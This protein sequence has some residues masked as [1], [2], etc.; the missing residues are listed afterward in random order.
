MW[1]SFQLSIR[2][3]QIQHPPITTTKSTSRANEGI[4]RLLKNEQILYVY[5]F[6]LRFPRRNVKLNLRAFYLW[7][8]MR[9][10][11]QLVRHPIPASSMACSHSAPMLYSD[12]ERESNDS[13]HPHSP[14]KSHNLTR[15]HLN[16]S[17]W[18]YKQNNRYNISF[19]NAD[20]NKF[21]AE[22]CRL[23]KF[24]RNKT[25]FVKF[26]IIVAGTARPLRSTKKISFLLVILLMTNKPATNRTL[27]YQQKTF[28]TYCVTQNS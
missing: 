15:A 9:L 25:A 17:T 10:E 23:G 11:I 26:S 7:Q 18:Q 12:D 27:Q 2:R 1:L 16:A 8:K 21:Y 24:P 22:G 3:N 20:D 5:C 4:W 19:Q 28:T 6:F 13:S 14:P